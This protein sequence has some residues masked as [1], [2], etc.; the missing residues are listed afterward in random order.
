MAE[1]ELIN[2]LT[3]TFEADGIRLLTGTKAVR[4]FNEQGN[5]ALK[6]EQGQGNYGEIQAN[7]VLVAI[8]RKPDLEELSLEN[9]GVDYT[10]ALLSLTTNFRHPP[11]T[12]TLAAIL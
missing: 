1:R 4:V 10:P 7:R 3:Q 6:Y 2:I 9:A 11:A 12:Y 5:V 8:G